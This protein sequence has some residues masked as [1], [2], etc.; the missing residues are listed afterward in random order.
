MAHQLNPEQAMAADFMEGPLLVL[1]GAGSGKTRVVTFRIA[2]LLNKGVPAHKILGLT[3]TNKAASEMKERVHSLTQSSVEI[4]TFHALGVRILRESIEHLGFKRSFNIYDEDDTEKLV[5]ACMAEFSAEKSGEVKNIRSYI[6]QAKNALIAPDQVDRAPFDFSNEPLFPKIYAQYQR[7][8]FEYNAVDFD[9]LLYLVVRLFQ[10][11]P[12]ILDYYQNRWSYLLID[13]YQDTNGAQYSIVRSLVEKSRNLFVVGDP[14]QSIYS[15]RGANMQNILNFESDFPGAQVVRLTQNYRSHMN[16]LQAA[17]TLIGFNK[18]RYE[19]NLWSD[20]GEGEKIKY[21]RGDS[22]RHEAEYIANKIYKHHT[23]DGIPL[24]E[25]VIFYRTNALSRGFEDCLLNKRIPYVIIG[26]IS[27]YQR[28][29]VKDILAFLRIVHSD[30]DFISFM[31]TINLPKRGIGDATIEKLYQGASLEQMPILDYCEAIIQDKP[32]KYAIR[33]TPKHKLGLAQ[34]L[35]IIKKLQQL[36]KENGS[37]KAIVQSTIED[38]CYLGVLDDDPETSDD[39]KDNLE[40]LVSKAAEWEQCVD[41]PTLSA[42]LE[43][44]SLKSSLDEAEGI[45]DRLNLMTL[46]N[47]KGLEFK[48]VFIAGLEENLLPH[49]NSRGSY[50]ALEEERRLCYVGMTRAKEYLYL[51]NT[52][53]RRTWGETRMQAQSK[54]LNEIPKQYIEQVGS[55]LIPPQVKFSSSFRDQRSPLEPFSSPVQEEVRFIEPEGEKEEF[56]EGDA[57]FHQTFGVGFI[58]KVYQ[59]GM[60]LTYKIFFNKEQSEKTLVAKFAPIKKL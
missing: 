21:Y 38:S 49:A 13:E 54:F 60:G 35:A 55:S 20:L 11:K 51:T 14:D 47:G 15:W 44:L 17:N 24:K 48:V 4:S 46:H 28:K 34:Y 36:A 18:N 10:E 26:G 1:A 3:F 23:I 2:N 19:K 50:E 57:I 33:L 27:F 8:L 25:M 16:I 7:K 53:M 30:S 43:E 39:R 40:A 37:I 42:F 56:N 58:S 5:K 12:E 22:D 52:K 59:G 45:T 32:L 6:S 29:E 9:D 31:R 41:N